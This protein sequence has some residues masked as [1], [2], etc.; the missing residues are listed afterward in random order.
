MAETP[1]LELL[2][3]FV[4]AEAAPTLSAA[5][6]ARHVTKSAVSQQMK[7]L[8]AQL[9]VTLFERVG[10][11]VRPTE[12]ARALASSLR[13]AFAV[14]DGSVDAARERQGAVRGVVRIGAP[15]PFASFW[16]RPRLAA[17][18]AAH[19]ELVVEVSFGVP[20]ELERRLIDGELELAIL[21]RSAEA[22]PIDTTPLY[23]EAFDAYASPAWVERHGLPKTADDFASLRF[24]AFDEDLP[25]HA[26]WW[27][28]TF[29][30]RT[31]LRGAVACRVASLDEMRALAIG[32]A[33][34][35]VLPTY[36][37]A[38]AVAARRLV[39]IT[40]RS[41]KAI[42]KN[43]IVLAWRRGITKAARLEAVREALRSPPA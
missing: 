15:R 7:V 6:A 36:F 22:S 40:P 19:E 34:Y 16:L 1:N 4:T 33:A 25:M 11:H 14:I 42:A 21:A 23:V 32:S 38:D 18:L 20:S 27:R 37:V 9:G 28:A 5:A 10:R 26:P 39:S 2:R 41:R 12:A 30:A 17:L 8:E 43:P 31:S 13:E 29:G 35:A 3:T 24:V